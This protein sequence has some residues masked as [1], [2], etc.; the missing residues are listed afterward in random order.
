MAGPM[1]NTVLH[2]AELYELIADYIQIL[3][4]SAFSRCHNFILKPFLL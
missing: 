3:E 2:D 4:G 1:K